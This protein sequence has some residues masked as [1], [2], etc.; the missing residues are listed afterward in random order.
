MRQSI[1][2]SRSS[3]L[4]VWAAPAASFLVWAAATASLVAWGL[5]FWPNDGRP[6]AN[7]VS[8]ETASNRAGAL[9]S[10]LGSPSQTDAPTANLGKVLGAST[11]VAAEPA[12][13]SL[14][15]RLALLGI[16]KRGKEFSA[17][18]AVD[19]QAAKPYAKG[20][21]VLPGLVLQSVN[22]QQAH[23]GASISS[24]AQIQ[25]DMPKRAE[26]ARGVVQ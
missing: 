15:S 11:M 19:G 22:L 24:P 17:L 8:M 16:A 10:N 2:S 26:P 5:A 7:S 6:L 14:V 18:I 21:E 23:L 3:A 4:P 20:A 9:T 1:A 13:P 12:S 25:L